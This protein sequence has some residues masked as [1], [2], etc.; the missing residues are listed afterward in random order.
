MAKGALLRVRSWVLHHH[1]SSQPCQSGQRE[2][3]RRSGGKVLATEPVISGHQ[4]PQSTR[5]GTRTRNLLLRR[6]APY[7][8]G[9]TSSGCP[10]SA[11][12]LGVAHAHS[13]D[14]GTAAAHLA[15]GRGGEECPKAQALGASVFVRALGL[16]VGGQPKK[17]A[18]TVKAVGPVGQ[19]QLS[20]N[21]GGRMAT[22]AGPTL[23]NPGP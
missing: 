14:W 17:L 2:P 23:R 16:A 13:A 6:E 9:H 4:V 20:L 10:R 15:L 19:A 5:G 3:F 22:A 1:S 12:E 7:P 21:C 18:P 11:G 8:L